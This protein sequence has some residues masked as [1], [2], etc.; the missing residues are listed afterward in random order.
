MKSRL[1]ASVALSALVLA[2]ATGCTFITPQTTKLTY[3]PSDGV[4]IA[5]SG[6]VVVRN[7]LVVANDAGDA[8]V[9]VGALV[10]TGTTD[11]T[12]TIEVEGVSPIRVE[13]PAGDLISFGSNA[14]ALEL[15][16]FNAKPGA[17]VNMSFQSGGVASG[18]TAVP[19]LDGTL[20]FYTDLAPEQ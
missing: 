14:E 20:Y 2:G 1:V 5:E 6:P 12:M 18:P 19:V 17:T 15:E 3:S 13:V 8:G 16:G 4:S 11:E 10:N 7:A 9:F